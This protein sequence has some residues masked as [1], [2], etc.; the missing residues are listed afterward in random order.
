MQPGVQL[1]IDYPLARLVLSNP[2]KHNSLT[3]EALHE[4]KGHLQRIEDD[5]GIRVVIVTGAGDRTFCSGMSLGEIRSGV[6]DSELFQSLTDR[7]A[8]LPLPKIAAMNGSAY[9]GGVEIGLCCDF[10][11]GV[12]GMKVMVPAARFGLC[13][14]PRG[15]QRY[16]NR[17]GVG[18]AK[19][20]LVAS[21]TLDEAALVRIGYLHEAVE[22][23]ELQDEVERW[24]GHIAAL[25]P[26]LT[27][28]TLHQGCK[29]IQ[30]LRRTVF[31]VRAG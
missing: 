29:A 25:A 15:V 5:P 8:A 28:A 4:F 18:A 16:V 26:Q 2:G 14:P 12:T 11:I 19:R 23:E 21:E 24:A 31:T 27:R 9:G 13:Y 30:I 22:F 7:L 1:S 17:L 6:I 20:L 3:V 10:R